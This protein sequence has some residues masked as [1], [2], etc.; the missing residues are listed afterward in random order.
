MSSL[1]PGR[2]LRHTGHPA[3]HASRAEL[4]ADSR[5]G[6]HRGR[7][8]AASRPQV[9]CP[10]GRVRRPGPRL[11]RAPP[12]RRPVPPDHR[13]VH[14]RRGR[15]DGDRD[16]DRG[17]PPA[18]QHR[19]GPHPQGLRAL[20]EL[21]A[22]YPAGLPGRLAPPG[23]GAGIITRWSNRAWPA[24]AHRGRPRPGQPG[25]AG[26]SPPSV[27]TCALAGAGQQE[28]CKAYL[29]EMRWVARWR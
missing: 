2:I 21:T 25:R 19:G 11:R 16:L 28:N 12:R 15:P 10:A 4:A 7:R 14:R 22:A 1:D 20:G 27:A 29:I 18:G 23:V 26:H 5:R 3:C 6:S 13:P 24:C 9:S 17:R 8:T